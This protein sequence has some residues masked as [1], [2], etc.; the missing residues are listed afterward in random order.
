MTVHYHGTPITPHAVLYDLA[1]RS[2]LAA[3]GK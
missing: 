1:G 2:A 3:E